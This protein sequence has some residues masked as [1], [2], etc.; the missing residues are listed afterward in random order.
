M[1]ICARDEM[2]RDIGIRDAGLSERLQL[3][4]D[5]TLEKAKKVARQKEAVKEQHLQLGLRTSGESLG[6]RLAV[7]ATQLRSACQ[8]CHLCNSIDSIVPGAILSMVTER[9][10]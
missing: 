5:L 6:T 4:P 7:R 3:D 10:L 9:S 8:K 1:A 2:L